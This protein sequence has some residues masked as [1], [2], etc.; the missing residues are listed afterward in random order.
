MQ[1]LMSRSR[2]KASEA[3][4]LA[5]WQFA[6]KESGQKAA[7]ER[8]GQAAARKVQRKALL[9]CL[10]QGGVCRSSWGPVGAASG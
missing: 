6:V 7:A 8:P 10:M 9:E 5:G 1:E 3:P 4:A 2:G